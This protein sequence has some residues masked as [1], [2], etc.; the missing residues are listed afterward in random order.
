MAVIP[1]V[2]PLP[3]APSRSDDSSLF[4][5][6]A[7]AFVAALITMVNQFNQ[8]VAVIPEIAMAINYNTTSGT[9]I[10]IGT[11]TKTF[12]AETDG[13][14]QIGQFVIA[15]SAADPTNY[16]AGQIMSY[17]P[18]DGEL[19]LEVNAIGGAGTFDDWV[20]AVT[21]PGDLGSLAPVAFTGS[22]ADLDNG[23]VSL[24]KLSDIASARLLGRY[25]AGAGV[26]Q[27]IS[28]GAGLTLDAG[29]GVLSLSGG[30]LTL[31]EGDYGDITVGGGG[32]TMTV[33][34]GAITYDKIQNVGADKL[35][36]S[37]AGGV[38]TEITCTAAGRALLDD[39]SAADQRTTLGLG[40]IATLAKSTT[41][42]YWAATADKALT[43]DVAWAAA[44][45]QPL[46]Q[47][48]TIAVDMATGVNF[49]TTMTGN[50]A[51]GNPTNAKEGQS[52]VI[53]LK[54]DATGHRTLTYGNKWKFIGGTPTLSTDA[55]ARDL[56]Y[57]QVLP[58]G[59]IHASLTKAPA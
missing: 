3:P 11:G 57:Y 56:L 37:A 18:E 1:V 25:T 59:D 17:N 14:Q 50:R 2:S 13:L 54:Q 53:E 58:G 55:N 41:A 52:G 8:A 48:A 42:Q 47:A 21:P 31:A 19:I 39:A 30:T 4:A 28:I 6:K 10:L 36:G 38:V 23:S 16:M 5:Q 15:A 29:T 9:E 43:A 7:D 45:F 49:T 44:V 51:L 32:S 20:I 46:I 24:A 26:P 34:A 40:S 22:G 35:L 12:I 33:D 27:V